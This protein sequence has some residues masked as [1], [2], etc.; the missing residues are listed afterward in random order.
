[1]IKRIMLYS[2][3]V[4]LSVILLVLI[5]FPFVVPGIVEKNSK[6]W[7]GRKITL[8]KMRVNYFTGTVRLYDFDLYEKDDSTVFVGFDTLI[9]NTEPYRL[10]S[11]TFVV[12]Q[13]YLQGLFVDV[14]MYDSAFNFDDLM[15]L[16]NDTTAVVEEESTDEDPMKFEL[17]D[18]ELKDA[19]FIIQD[20]E[21]QDSIEIKN[22]DFFLPHLV[23]NQE[24]EDSKADIRFDF[25]NEG[26][27][28]SIVDFNSGSGNFKIDFILGNYDISGYQEFA[29]KYVEI[30]KFKGI[31]DLQMVL[32]GNIDLPLQTSVT[33][34]FTLS[35][36]ALYDDKDNVMLGTDRFLIDVKEASLYEKRIIIDSIYFLQPSLYFEAYDSTSNIAQFMNR[37]M[38]PEEQDSVQ[39]NEEELIAENVSKE[40]EMKEDSISNNST[41]QFYISIN[42]FLLEKGKI[43]VVD[44]THE[45]TFEYDISDIQVQADS[46][47]NNDPTL[48]VDLRM[49]LSDRGKMV[50][51]I[52]VDLAN[53]GEMSLDF[54]ISSLMLEDFDVFSREATGYPLLYGDMYMKSETVVRNDSIK[55]QN[56]I[57]IHNIKFGHRQQMIGP[58]VKFAMFLLK[59]KDKVVNIE[60]P[61]E[62]PVG[63]SATEIGDM[64]WD[65]FSGL[66]VK[67]A[68]TPFKFIGSVLNVFDTDIKRIKYDYMDTTLTDHKQRQLNNILKLEDH[69]EE[70]KIDLVYYKDSILER[71]E[72]AK[73]IVA[74][75]MGIKEKKNHEKYEKRLK[76]RVNKQLKTDTLTLEAACLR[77]ADRGRVDAVSAMLDS[78]R[79]QSLRKYL[80]SQRDTTDIKLYMSKSSAPNNEDNNPRFEVK[81][82]MKDDFIEEKYINKGKDYNK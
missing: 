20:A 64:I 73:Y 33:S 52:L 36:L 13:F 72:I 62:G 37:V 51:D 15:E 25:K 78:A 21:I 74:E 45:N 14:I 1:M 12:E 17:S 58:P 3:A 27:F 9:V 8:D 22:F 11:N 6:E 2:L 61:I 81:L 29:A 69:E 70:L 82:G 30:G 44:R 71:Q 59:D 35:D 39:Q 48:D 49:D 42:T 79:F 67:V 80:L 43:D 50:S 28:E 63:E 68:S 66:L 34:K 18:M 41:Q 5:L 7:I 55:S 77:L 46:L 19:M 31:V 32:E 26:Y 4:T 60:M 54:T 65:T 24:E 38:P 75:Q 76:N 10:F 16:G 57:V 56:E 53:P 40:E 23:W 47:S